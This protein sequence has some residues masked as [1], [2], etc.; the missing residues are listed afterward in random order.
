M[1]KRPR[2][3]GRKALPK[4][5]LILDLKMHAIK[6][7]AQASI[8]LLEKATWARPKKGGKAEAIKSLRGVIKTMNSLCGTMG[9]KIGFE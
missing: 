9:F 3:S 1:S 4:G 2:S 8:A 6:H 7:N 5:G